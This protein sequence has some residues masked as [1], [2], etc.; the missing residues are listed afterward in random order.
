MNSGSSSSSSSV[1]E[2]SSSGNRSGRLRRP[3][4]TLSTSSS[5]RSASSHPWD[6]YTVNA[7]RRAP[8]PVPAR[9]LARVFRESYAKNVAAANNTTHQSSS[10]PP[11]EEKFLVLSQRLA[12]IENQVHPLENN[13]SSKKRSN[14]RADRFD[15]EQQSIYNETKNNL[16]RDYNMGADTSMCCCCGRMLVNCFIT[17]ASLLVGSVRSVELS[18]HFSNSLPMAVMIALALLCA[19]IIFAVV[20]VYSIQENDC[21]TTSTMSDASVALKNNLFDAGNNNIYHQNRYICGSSHLDLFQYSIVHAQQQQL[22][23]PRFG[24]TPQVDILD[25]SSYGYDYTWAGSLGMPFPNGELARDWTYFHPVPYEVDCARLCSKVVASVGFHAKNAMTNELE[26]MCSLDQQHQP[27]SL[28]SRTSCVVEGWDT[29]QADFNDCFLS[30]ELKNV[31][32]ANYGVAYEEQRIPM[33]IWNTTIYFA[34]PIVVFA[35]SPWEQMLPCETVQTATLSSCPLSAEQQENS[36]FNIDASS[37]LQSIQEASVDRYSYDLDH[38][39]LR[40]ELLSLSSVHNDKAGSDYWK[41]CI[42]Q[43]L[44]CSDYESKNCE[45]I[46]RQE[47]VGRSPLGQSTEQQCQGIISVTYVTC[48]NLAVTLGAALGYMDWIELALISAA[49]TMVLGCCWGKYPIRPLMHVIRKDNLMR[50]FHSN[51]KN[52]SNDEL[53]HPLEKHLS[54]PTNFALPRAESPPPKRSKKKK[55]KRTSRKEKMQSI[56]EEPRSRS[57]S[58]AGDRPDRVIPVVT[59]AAPSSPPSAERR[60]GFP[61][62]K[63]SMPLPPPP[64]AA[65][66]TRR[67][68]SAIFSEGNHKGHS[69]KAEQSSYYDIKFA[70]TPRRGVASAAGDDNPTRMIKL[71][72][73]Y[74]ETL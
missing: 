44:T 70:A 68:R 8:A 45:G 59:F 58:P 57:T 15:D 2:Y 71:D 51:Q 13:N 4:N 32:T 3:R 17:Q 24:A 23:D 52:N 66:P 40:E 63:F 61:V 55:K 49:A 21:I 34:A 65:L 7:K 60:R 9:E 73:L 47:C 48:P 41:P 56:E 19:K 37:F 36:D 16:R 74:V 64:P 1:L 39:S 69:P 29:D 22:Q 54:D 11:D 72:D 31:V 42:L 25:L 12:Q 26:C 5:I 33:F 46:G 67:D 30:E 43:G 10:A 38:G 28:N 27:N 18:A 20:F 53:Y 62:D 35:T 6:E 50:S 14:Q